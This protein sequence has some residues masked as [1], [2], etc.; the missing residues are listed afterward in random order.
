[1]KKNLVVLTNLY[2]LPWDSTWGMFNWN[3]IQSLKKYFNI[4][5][6]CPILVK[7]V[8][9]NSVYKKKIVDDNE[10][11]VC[12]FPFFYAPFILKNKRHRILYYL[13]LLFGR[14]YIETADVILST[15]LYPNGF[16]GVDLGKLF[17]IKAFIKIHGSDVN[18]Q[19]KD[20]DIKN[21]VVK[22]I[23]SVS[24][25]I[26]VSKALT[27]EFSES[28]SGCLSQNY[29]TTIYNGVDTSVFNLDMATGRD[30]FLFIGTLKKT[31]GILDLLYSYKIYLSRGGGTPLVIIGKGELEEEIGQYIFNNNLNKKINVLG[32]VDHK[33]ISGYIKSSVGL[34][35]PSYN[36]G[37]PN[38]V[39]ESLSCGKPVLASEVG[40]IPEIV[41][42]RTGILV[43]AGNIE[44][45]SIG[46]DSLERN[47]WDNVLISSS[48]SSLSW[49]KNIEQLKQVLLGGD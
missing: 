33:D 16:A 5:V 48:V 38:V 24:G 28:I 12:Y 35:L 17:N 44:E 42:K 25:V 47:E 14:K 2:P 27:K 20:E 49:E 9:K 31:K 30:Y 29:I 6:M 41:Q 34:C 36:E 19:L 10:V 11:T 39:L 1:M 40:G 4:V 22:N 43:E 13:C 7:D 32:G 8:I 15:W 37:V 21:V 18:Y 23:Q 3:Q 46:L 45:I 26:S